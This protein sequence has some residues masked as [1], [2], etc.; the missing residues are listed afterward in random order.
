MPLAQAIDA[1]HLRSIVGLDVLFH[2]GPS[3]AQVGPVHD[4]WRAPIDCYLHKID[5]VPGSH[6]GAVLH[7]ARVVAQVGVQKVS[8]LNPHPPDQLS[9]FAH[10]QGAL[11]STL[12]TQQVQVQ[13]QILLKNNVS[14]QL[15]HSLER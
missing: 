12:C 6:I 11:E 8:V 7:P 1:S 4:F 10:T 5:I 15:T 13:V 14:S 2:M 9:G 3:S